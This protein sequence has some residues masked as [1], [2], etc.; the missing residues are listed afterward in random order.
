MPQATDLVINNGAG[1]PVAKT[2][3]LV[4]PAAGI[5]GVA[6]WELQ[7][8]A[9]SSVFPSLSAVLRPDSQIK[10]MT[11]VF[12]WKVPQSYT[13]ADTS[14]VL[15]GAVAEAILTIKMPDAFPEAEKA[16]FAAYIFNGVN[17][18]SVKA[19]LRGR[20]AFT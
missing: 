2:F 8:A 5:N 16:N 14:L 18:T 19:F 1:T 20:V 10:G 6:M 17:L 3:T 13:D 7:E 11:S 9:N 15:R 12:K 4:A